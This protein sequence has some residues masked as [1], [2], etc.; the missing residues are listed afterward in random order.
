MS[1]KTFDHS[2]SALEEKLAAYWNLVGEREAI[3]SRIAKA[4]TEKDNVNERV[5]RKVISDYEATLESVNTELVPLKEEIDELRHTVDQEI[6]QVDS[7]IEELDDAIA[8]VAFRHRV[9]EYDA[10]T[11]DERTR[12]LTPKVEESRRR[13]D[14]L[15]ECLV[16]M[17]RRRPN[18][19]ATEPE[20]AEPTE[21]SAKPTEGS[22]KP[23][24]GS[25][26]PT[27]GTAK[28]EPTN[29]TAEPAEQI[30]ELE[31]PKEWTEELEL[32]ELGE[33]SR[34]PGEPVSAGPATPSSNE[35]ESDP[36]A[37]LTDPA[38]SIQA[39]AQSAP[40]PQ[41]QPAGAGG[42]TTS[43]TA[44]PNLMIRSGA[45][46]GKIVPL[47]PIT[48]SIGREHDNSIELKDPEVARYHARVLYENGRYHVEDL[49][50]ST[51]TWVNGMKEKRRV[52]EE[53]DV[54][55]IGGTELVFEF[56]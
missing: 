30:I 7:V 21:G 50:S 17:D 16:A 5:F 13:R 3:E 10:T 41:Q 39:Q 45:H 43:A 48:M 9:G 46:N 42:V 53:G 6:K 54:I 23:T 4:K 51:G 12:E 11:L 29:G 32:L 24:E 44:Y 34:V 25:A 14:E 19:T 28:P 1:N 18:K 33:S 35:P 38:P 15:T 31:D 36:L 37:A 40:T 27:E 22:A 56:V 52:L 55:R 20:L 47:L 26:K 49:E 2:P 8:E